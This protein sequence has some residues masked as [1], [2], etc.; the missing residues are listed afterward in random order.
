MM[1]LFYS[2][3]SPFARKVFICAKEYCLEKEVNL[4]L[5]HPIQEADVLRAA[6]PL[7]KVPALLVDNEDLLIES[8]IICR[9]LDELALKSTGTLSLVSPTS[10]S[11]QTVTQL[12]ALADG[13]MGAGYLNVMERLRP[14][15]QQSAMWKERWV[16]A[17]L[18]T[19]NYLERKS[20]AAIEQEEHHLGQVAVACA[21]G[22]LDFRMDYLAW[23]ERAP[24]LATWF[25]GYETREIFKS[26]A[27]VK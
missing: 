8:P 4:K 19:L 24:R 21:L 10:L 23:R 2:Q 27:P 6:N 14:E 18:D 17:M 5:L 25:A 3:T 15:E 11:V 7:C 26:T 1:T 16:A 20:L 12:E 9:Y 13:I 22:Y